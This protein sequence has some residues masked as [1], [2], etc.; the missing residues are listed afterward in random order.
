MSITTQIPL[1]ENL[2]NVD[3]KLLR[4]DDELGRLRSAVETLK[5]DIRE[6]ELR[7]AADREAISTM[8]KTRNELVADMR[9]MNQQIE[10]SREKMGRSRNE[11][12][13]V[14]AQREFEELRKLVRDRDDE[15]GKLETLLEKARAS[16]QD[17]ET[18]LT[19]LGLELEGNAEG[20]TK[21]LADR[22]AE[23]EA[24]L[25][26]REAAHKALPPTL[27]RR[28]ETIRQRRPK[29]IAQTTDGTC[30][31]C[32]IS[33][34]PMLFQQMMRRE[35]FEQCPQ[36][37]RILYFVPRGELSSSGS[38]PEPEADGAT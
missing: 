16:I 36:C 23:R 32:H 31:G 38:S 33:L 9:Q 4:V 2:S 7:R 35:Q 14:A 1:L 6:F 13:S 17:T 30:N 25:A 22:E 3:E 37:R 12:E 28:Y 26:Q 21:A 29:A 19:E 18:K 8:E 11:R 24:L 15:V 27:F 10:R 20:T 34:P 5:S